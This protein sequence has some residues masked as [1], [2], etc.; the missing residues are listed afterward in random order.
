[1]KSL[2]LRL[3]KICRCTRNVNAILMAVIQ[4]SQKRKETNQFR[5]VQEGFA[6]ACTHGSISSQT[7][8]KLANWSDNTAHDSSVGEM[9]QNE[10]HA[11]R[12]HYEQFIV[13]K[14]FM[15]AWG[16]GAV[17]NQK[18]NLALLHDRMKD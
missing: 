16:I 5:I 1:M 17:N 6:C 12:G 13:V 15:M 18:F 9:S 4:F 3:N 11:F 10:T 14:N 8:S 7:P 2:G